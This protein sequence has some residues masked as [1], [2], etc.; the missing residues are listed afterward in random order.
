M[1]GQTMGTH[2]HRFTIDLP[3]GW[4]DQ[5]LF[6][7]PE[8][9]GVQ[10]SLTLQIDRD[11]DPDELDEYAHERLME[12][13]ETL[14]NAEVLKE[15]EREM[16]SG[17]SAIEAV[18]KWVPSEGRVVFRTMVFVEYDGAFYTFCGDFT[19]QTRKTIGLEVA[20]MIDSFAPQAED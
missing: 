15:E 14:S 16:P 6:E 19:K 9:G 3:D 7:G 10:H 2:N 4:E 8:A 5:T 11:P 20:R 12:A 13:V 1:I 18:F 17:A